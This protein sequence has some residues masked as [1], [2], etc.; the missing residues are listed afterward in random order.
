MQRKNT[1][2]TCSGTPDGIDLN[3][4]YSYMW[5]YDNEGSSGDGCNETY[6]GSSP[7]SEPETSAIRD[8]VESHDFPIAFNYHSYGNLLIYPFG[9]EYENQAPQDDVDIMIEYGEDMVQYNNYALGTGPDLLY[10][11]NGEAC[12]WMY[13]EHGIYAYTPEIGTWSDGFWPPSDRI[14]PLAEENLHPNKFVAWAVGSKYKVNMVFEEDFYIQNESYDFNY[15]IKNQGLE[16]NLTLLPAVSNDEYQAILQECDVGIISLRKDFKTDNIPNKILN[17]LDF[18]LPILASI[19]P[20]ND[21]RS[22]IESFECGLVSENG[23]NQIFI[24]H[25]RELLAN[26]SKREE[27]GANGYGLLKEVFDVKSA[28]KQVLKHSKETNS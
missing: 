15:S 5:G 2:E 20:D 8:F 3:R 28:V 26:K 22:L 11:V 14:L 1:R 24:S 7:F 10:T 27:M 19:N 6:R 12:D 13:G 25:T 23:Q 4:N 18:Q 9:Y 16:T 21:I 17:Y